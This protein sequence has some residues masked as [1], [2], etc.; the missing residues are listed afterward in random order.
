[1]AVLAAI[2]VIAVG[3]GLEVAVF[4]KTK[5]TMRRRMTASSID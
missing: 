1:V 5:S 4:L 3:V 2:I